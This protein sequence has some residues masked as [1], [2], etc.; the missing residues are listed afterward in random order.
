LTGRVSDASTGGAI[1]NALIELRRTNAGAPNMRSTLSDANGAFS[2]D[3]IVAGAVEARVQ[4]A[5]YGAVTV[6]VTVGETGAPPLDVKL[7]PS[8]GLALRIVDGRDGR[9]LNGWYYAESASGEGSAGVITGSTEPSRVALA[10]GSYRLV[11]GA[12]AYAP[13]TLTIVAPGEQTIAL[14]PGATII[15]SSSSDSF[16]FLRIVDAAGQPV[17][18]GPGPAPALIRIDPAPGQTRIDNI[19]PGTYTLQL[20]AGGNV[21]RSAPVTVREGETVPAKL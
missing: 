10:A 21:L 3:Q 2:F 5:G 8:S 9:P 14:T 4:K 18:F 1:D 11:V 7:S 13:R 20:I 17:R 6:G 16:A 12:A 19:A 15:V